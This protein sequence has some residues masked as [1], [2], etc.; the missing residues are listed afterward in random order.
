MDET[1]KASPPSGGRRG[2]LKAAAVGAAGLATLAAPSVSRAQTVTLRFQSTWPGRDIQQ[3]FAQDYVNRVNRMG[4]GRLRLELLA[5]GAVVG[6][7]Q[8]LDAVSAGTLDGGHGV[9]A[10]WFGK[11]KA[12]SLFGTAPPWFGD[13]NQ[14]LVSGARRRPRRASRARTAASSRPGR[15][16]AAPP[17]SPRPTV[18]PQPI[19]FRRFSSILA[20]KAW[21]LSQG[22]SLPIRTAR[23]LVM[24]P[25]ST[26]WTQTR[27]SV[28]A[29]AV[30]SGVLSKRPR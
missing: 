13:A 8:L 6:A 9:S 25:L 10:Y 29:K 7:F 23:S 26:V 15:S 17:L 12:F 16:R 14:L 19:A 22:W 20:R 18:A 24:S 27:S 21:V 4:G 1:G 30:T 2:A 28:S 3:E 11:N 5:A